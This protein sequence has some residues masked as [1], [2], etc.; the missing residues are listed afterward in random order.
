MQLLSEE[1]FLNAQDEYGEENFRCRYR[2]RSAER[3]PAGVNLEEELANV[4]RRPA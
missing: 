1:E 4:E 2:R 3:N